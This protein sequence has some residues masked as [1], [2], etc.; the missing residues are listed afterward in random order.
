MDFIELEI[1]SNGKSFALI[2]RSDI[3]SNV[4]R[5]SNTL[6]G[7]VVGNKPFCLQIKACV[8]RIWNPSC[9]LEVHSRENGFFFF[10][11]GDAVECDRILQIGPWIFDGRLIVLKKWTEQIGLERDLISSVPI[12]VCFPSLHLKLQSRSIISRIASLLG[13]PIHMTRT[14]Q[15]ERDYLMLAV[16]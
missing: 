13:V 10:K 16:L 14:Q 2:P 12:W 5:W 3:L 6:V 1:S 11:F 8:N 4:D 7:Y 9:S 15:M